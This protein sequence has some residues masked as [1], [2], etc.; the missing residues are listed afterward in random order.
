[1]MESD[2]PAQPEELRR[3]ILLFVAGPHMRFDA[4]YRPTL[5]HRDLKFGTWTFLLR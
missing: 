4:A 1:M 3:R 2:P 5:T